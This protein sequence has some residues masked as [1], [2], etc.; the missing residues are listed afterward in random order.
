MPVSGTYTIS[1]LCSSWQPQNLNHSVAHQSYAACQL[2]ILEAI[3][4]YVCMAHAYMYVCTKHIHTS[5][6]NA[7]TKWPGYTVVL[8]LMAF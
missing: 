7:Q 5:V 6:I 1:C 3:G 8:S 4:M 2:K